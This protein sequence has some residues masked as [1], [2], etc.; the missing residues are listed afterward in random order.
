MLLVS[1]ME[2]RKLIIEIKDDEDKLN[3]TKEFAFEEAAEGDSS[4]GAADRLQL[5]KHLNV[6]IT[7]QDSEIIYQVQFLKGYKLNIYDSFKG[8]KKL[9]ASKQ[10]L[11]FET[12]K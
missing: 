9:L 3:F 11:W 8:Q 6:E 12:I 4:S 5:G 10:V 7:K 2:G 1:N